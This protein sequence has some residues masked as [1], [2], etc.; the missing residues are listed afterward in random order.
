MK[1]LISALF[2]TAIFTSTAFAGNGSSAMGPLVECDLNKGTSVMT[3]MAC[4]KAKLSQDK[5]S[6]FYPNGDPSE[7]K[8][9]GNH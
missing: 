5:V 7:R 6:K 4:E 2:M 9:G 1:K 3:A 8:G